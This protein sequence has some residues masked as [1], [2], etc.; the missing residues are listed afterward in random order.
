V[1]PVFGR[2][3]RVADHL[4][5]PCGLAPTPDASIPSCRTSAR[6]PNPQRLGD[7]TVIW[8]RGGQ[9]H[10]R[11]AHVGHSGEVTPTCTAEPA[12]QAD[13]ADW[14]PVWYA[15]SLRLRKDAGLVRDAIRW[16]PMSQQAYNAE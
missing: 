13:P 2:S 8:P 15:T 16:T 4:R 3:R 11:W 1:T 14:A 10:G 6:L 7:L 12:R 5:T 9:V